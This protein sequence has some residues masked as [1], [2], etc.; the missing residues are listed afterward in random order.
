MTAG[1]FIEATVIQGILKY[2]A[3]TAAGGPLQSYNFTERNY[4]DIDEYFINT[5][6][7]I[8]NSRN[9]TSY[10]HELLINIEY[11]DRLFFFLASLIG[12]C[13]IWFINRRIGLFL[14]LVVCMFWALSTRHAG[15]HYFNACTSLFVFL[16]SS[17]SP[18]AFSH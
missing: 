4:A 2:Q 11:A 17:L 5:L 13:G 3:A 6:I 8:N 9:Q 7:T 16:M 18:P 14:T 10:L 15:P 12:C 1:N